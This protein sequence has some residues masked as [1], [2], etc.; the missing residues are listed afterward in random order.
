MKYAVLPS[1]NG[2][3]NPGKEFIRQIE[4]FIYQAH[5]RNVDRNTG[6]LLTMHWLPVRAVQAMGSADR[7]REQAAHRKLFPD[8]NL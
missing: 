6:E 3:P 8:I 2:F 1:D 5:L 4:D 7:A